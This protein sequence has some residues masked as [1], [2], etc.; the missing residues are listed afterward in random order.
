MGTMRLFNESHEELKVLKDTPRFLKRLKW[1]GFWGLIL[2]PLLFQIFQSM[3]V[4]AAP[5]PDEPV[6][7]EGDTA[8]S[9]LWAAKNQ[10]VSLAKKLLDHGLDPN[11]AGENG[12]TPLMWASIHGN[13]ELLNDLLKHGANLDQEYSN[14]FRALAYATFNEHLEAVKALLN[15]G[16]KV[17]AADDEGMTALHIA[18][19]VG[20]VPITQ[21][22]LEKGADPMQTNTLGRTPYY[23][24][25]INYCK[26][27]KVLFQPLPNLPDVE[28]FRNPELLEELDQSDHETYHQHPNKV[29]ELLFK[30]GATR[31]A[32]TGT[33]KKKTFIDSPCLD[34]T[35]ATI[36]SS[37][38]LKSLSEFISKIS[39]GELSDLA[40]TPLMAASYMGKLQFVKDLLHHHGVN[41]DQENSTG[42]RA[43]SFAA[44]NG[45]IEI[46]Q[47]LLN[48]GADM[49]HINK[50]EKSALYYALLKNTDDHE[51]LNRKEA[52]AH[53]LLDLGAE[54]PSNSH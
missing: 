48:A 17:N 14:G 32:E 3:D 49:N 37:D 11:Y 9:I 12:E 19:G 52:V 50:I 53:L 16:A 40:T 30:Y 25:N 34:I 44:L 29:A 46:V 21:A 1:D 38:Q 7:G 8:E 13:V 18:A 33:L 4:N 28:R 36:N 39:S 47:E 42:S 2:L 20:S 27:L 26:K 15:A 41:L 6:Q 10:R 24:S 43:L 22:L 35:K 45:H 54:H 31:V 23:Y 5:H 51:T